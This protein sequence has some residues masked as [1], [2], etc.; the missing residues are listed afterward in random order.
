MSR[1]HWIGHAGVHQLKWHAT[2]DDDGLYFGNEQ[3][4]TIE[5]NLYDGLNVGDPFSLGQQNGSLDDG[6]G[7]CEYNKKMHILGNY[8]RDGTGS[9]N[10][11]VEIH[12]D[13]AKAKEN[14]CE[15]AQTGRQDEHKCIAFDTRCKSG[16]HFPIQGGHRA[17]NNRSYDAAA[18]T[19]GSHAVYFGQGANNQARDNILY[20]PNA[21][22]GVAA[23]ADT[24]ATCGVGLCTPNY[25][26]T[27][28][29]PF[30]GSFGDC[31]PAPDN[32]SEYAIC[33]TGFGPTIAPSFETSR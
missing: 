10:L 29:S 20:A 4:T 7:C 1:N 26:E 14:I 12:G 19:Q 5:G 9:V 28:S 8:F 24:N 22:G 18:H 2:G 32:R 3:Y 33:R 30:G 13:Y 25:T 16:A 27:S 11:G 31:V 6:C 21:S 15:I 23:I 17:I